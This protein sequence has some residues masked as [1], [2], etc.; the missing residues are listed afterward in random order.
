MIPESS[1]AAESSGAVLPEINRS[2]SNPSSWYH[3][4]RYS[5]RTGSVECVNLLHGKSANACMGDGS[6]RSMNESEW[7]D[8]GWENCLYSGN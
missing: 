4:N 6:A 5:G 7:K 2:T 8:L 3:V 1:N